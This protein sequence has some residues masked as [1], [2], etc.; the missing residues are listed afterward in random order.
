[1]HQTGA[2]PVR[3]RHMRRE[4]AR[5]TYASQAVAGT[6]VRASAQRHVE[7]R[8]AKRSDH[9]SEMPHGR[10]RQHSGELAGTVAERYGYPPTHHPQV[11]TGIYVLQF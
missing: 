1:M 8:H 4:H 3:I 2:V 10:T 7:E 9:E 5:A 6:H 11:L